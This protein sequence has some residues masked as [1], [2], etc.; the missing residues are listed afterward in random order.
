VRLAT[1]LGHFGSLILATSK[2]VDSYLFEPAGKTFIEGGRSKS[3]A[4]PTS[5]PLCGRGLLRATASPLGGASLI[6]DYPHLRQLIPSKD[7]TAYHTWG[8]STEPKGS[9]ITSGTEVPVPSF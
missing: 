4:Y 3:L 9:A 5:P 8:S 6:L 1:T 7:R 2:V